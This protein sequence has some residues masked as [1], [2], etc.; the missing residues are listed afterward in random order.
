M[1]DETFPYIE[2]IEFES[3]IRISGDFI[4]ISPPR[5]WKNPFEYT[6]IFPNKIHNYQSPHHV[7]ACTIKS[8]KDENEIIERCI[9]INH[10][11]FINNRTKT[12]HLIPNTYHVTNK[13]L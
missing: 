6:G 7:L 2:K 4:T 13:E 11:Y 9:I 1:D 5:Q 12:I 3:L 8:S 10:E